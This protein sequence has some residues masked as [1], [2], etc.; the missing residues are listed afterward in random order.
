MHTPPAGLCFFLGLP[1]GPYLL[2]LPPRGRRRAAEPG[3]IPDFY[4]WQLS[5]RGASPGV[6]RDRKQAPGLSLQG[7]RGQKPLL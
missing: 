4:V 5:H 2:L 3:P 7:E 1:G 6:C